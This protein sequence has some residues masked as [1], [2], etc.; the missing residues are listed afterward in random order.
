MKQRQVIDVDN[1]EPTIDL[2][3][4][5]VDLTQDDDV[6]VDGWTGRSHT[7]TNSA[8]QMTY[9]ANPSSA[10]A[11][12][13]SKRKRRLDAET[14]FN[15][16]VWPLNK[17]QKTEHASLPPVS[18][19]G[20]SREVFNLPDSDDEDNVDERRSRSKKYRVVDS[21]G[22]DGFDTDGGDYDAYIDG[23][24]MSSNHW[25]PL[26][27]EKLSDSEK[28]TD[29]EMS[30]E[31]EILSVEASL[32][33]PESEVRSKRHRYR[34]EVSVI[35]MQRPVMAKRQLVDKSL[36]WDLLNRVA[37]I[38]HW[39]HPLH[40]EKHKYVSTRHFKAP[41]SSCNHNLSL[42]SSF[43]RSPGY[44]VRI[45]QQDGWAVVCST[46]AGGYSDDDGEEVDAYNQEG[47]LIVWNDGR[48]EIVTGHR[49]KLPNT[50]DRY[51]YYTVNDI[52]FD[53]TSTI[54]VSSGNDKKVR[55]WK[56]E[57]DSDSKKYVQDRIL[58]FSYTPHEIA[59][60]PGTGKL[61][62]AEKRIRVYADY[63]TS[64]S[65]ATL[66]MVPAAAEH[67]VGEMIWGYGPTEH[68][69]CA[70]S[71]PKADDC[72]EGYHKVFDVEKGVSYDLD[73]K[74]AGDSIGLTPDG[75]TLVHA[76]RGPNRKHILRLYDIKRKD[77]RAIERLQM[78][79][80][81]TNLDGEVNSISISPDGIYI[82]AA[83]MDNR[84]HLYD[85]RML[86][87]G[88]L[89][90]Y[91][92]K[93][94][95]LIGPNCISYGVVRAGWVET[96]HSRLALV[97]GSIDGCIR[98]WEPLEAM[99]SPRNGIVLTQIHSDIGYFSLGD[100]TKN[101]QPLIV[102]DSCGGVYVFNSTKTYLRPL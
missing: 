79:S 13:H 22:D 39:Q 69:I 94:P 11:N 3:P 80:F 49:R 42:S 31:M 6:D 51:K 59:F 43:K 20:D 2:I 89:Y 97:S 77:G 7:Q 36:P 98:L 28:I 102:G 66:S 47:S 32:R 86:K 85:S 68:L 23:L 26:P 88:K 4:E 92:H 70:S 87:K 61:A 40:R 53:P 82:A 50:E 8:R 35:S 76:S 1:Y 21:D 71:E 62:I 48:E 64:V 38:S 74:E 72:F 27:A 30:E 90:E 14:A 95:S 45:V 17:A 78:E 57:A 99:A 46:C 12:T 67:S 24:L 19:R 101:E 73:S 44:I 60:K 16:C 84:I 15:D 96:E 52:K 65:Y 56:R 25:K 93:G 75:S 10:R 33:L 81:P 91:E 29:V 41:K 9:Y 58:P 55:V 18:L 5:T 100:R 83:R 63:K 34:S 54:F 37:N